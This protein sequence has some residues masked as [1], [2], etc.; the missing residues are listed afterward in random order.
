MILAYEKTHSLNES[1]QKTGCQCEGN[2]IEI[3]ALKQEMEQ[4]KVCVQKKDV[5]THTETAVQVVQ[6]SQTILANF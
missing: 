3:K 6:K 2:G 5:H 1:Q 4:S